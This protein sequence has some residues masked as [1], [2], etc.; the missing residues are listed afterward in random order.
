MWALTLVRFD[1]ENSSY[2]EFL[3][4]F[5]PVLGVQVMTPREQDIIRLGC[6]APPCGGSAGASLA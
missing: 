6:R 2:R 5:G 3:T 4:K 1:L